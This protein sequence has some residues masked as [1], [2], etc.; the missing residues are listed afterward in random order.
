MI[1]TALLAALFLVFAG[2]AP[3]NASPE[4][5]LTADKKSLS[6]SSEFAAPNGEYPT[7]ITAQDLYGETEQL[8][9][10]LR[11]EVAAATACASTAKVVIHH[12]KLPDTISGYEYVCIPRKGTRVEGKGNVLLHSPMPHVYVVVLLPSSK[13]RVLG[14]TREEAEPYTVHPHSLSPWKI[15]HLDPLK[16]R[17]IIDPLLP[18]EER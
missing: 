12:G 4:P 13:Y 9:R 3:R 17:K 18:K 8:I 1:K 10:M 7:I 16:E 2:C 14:L 11:R 6:Y 5:D 15:Y